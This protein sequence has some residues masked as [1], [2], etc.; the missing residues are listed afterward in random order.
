MARKKLQPL[1]GCHSDS[2]GAGITNDRLHSEALTWAV[3]I[4]EFGPLC[5][6]LSDTANE[7][8][9]PLGTAAEEFSRPFCAG[10][11]RYHRCLMHSNRISEHASPEGP[12][13]LQ[14]K[15]TV[16][17]VIEAERCLATLTCQPRRNGAVYMTMSP[18]PQPCTFAAAARM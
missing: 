5:L 6:I 8:P 2:G 17:L 18:Y 7:R 15:V 16:T 4:R 3:F 10:M 14:G 13:L 1:S 12:F 9:L 11:L